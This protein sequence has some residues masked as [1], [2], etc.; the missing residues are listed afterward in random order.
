MNA[1]AAGRAWSLSEMRS[2]VRPS[3]KAAISSSVPY[4][5]VWRGF[6]AEPERRGVDGSSGFVNCV[7]RSSFMIG[8]AA[9]GA[10]AALVLLMLV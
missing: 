6:P 8:V 4:R 10:I 5:G 9:V 2:F 1:A 3:K 7:W